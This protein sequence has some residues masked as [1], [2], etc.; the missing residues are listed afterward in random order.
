MIVAVN[1]KQKTVWK[2]AAYHLPQGSNGNT[3]EILARMVNVEIGASQVQSSNYLTAKLVL[4]QT[5]IFL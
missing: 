2:D 5:I 3:N 4:S 1:D